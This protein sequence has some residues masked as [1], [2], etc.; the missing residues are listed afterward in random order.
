[1]PSIFNLI[2]KLS[3]KSTNNHRDLDF[4]ELMVKRF[5]QILQ[6]LKLRFVAKHEMLIL[7]K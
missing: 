7:I 5:K 3:K 4:L 2:Q 1:M 6:L